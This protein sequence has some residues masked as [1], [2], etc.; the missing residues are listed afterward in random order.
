MAGEEMEE[1]DQDDT[2][3]KEE[4]MKIGGGGEVE[5]EEEEGGG[6]NTAATNNSTMVAE[7]EEGE[8]GEAMISEQLGR[9]VNLAIVGRIGEGSSSR[10][11]L[12]TRNSSTIPGEEGEV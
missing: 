2:G 10:K 3:L 9:K 4:R 7:R 5:E 8:K 6:W 12:A 11:S 1:R